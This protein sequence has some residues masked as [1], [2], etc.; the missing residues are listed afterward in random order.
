MHLPIGLTY[1]HCGQV[2]VLEGVN[3]EYMRVEP[4]GVGSVMHVVKRGGRGMHI[5]RDDADKW[6]FVRT[7]YLLNDTYS[8]IEWTRHASCRLPFARPSHWPKRDPLVAILAWTLMPNHFHL[9]LYEI[10]EGGIAKFMQRLCGSMT[11]YSNGK[12]DEQ[13]SIFQGSYKGRNVDTEQYLQYVLP[14]IVVKNVFELHPKGL[15]SAVQN[16]DDAWNFA[17]SYPFSSFATSAFGRTSPVIDMDISAELG[18]LRKDFK[19]SARDMLCAHT[20]SH[21]DMRGVFLEP[22]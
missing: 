3:I 19:Q 2:R 6:R 12:Y 13:G 11:T 14:Y 7:L 16:F 18:L 4:C 20:S 15:A 8:N 1:G 22:W 10:R 21:D 5:V 9:L 17:T